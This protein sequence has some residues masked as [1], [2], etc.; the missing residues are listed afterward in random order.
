MATLTS[1]HT[2]RF[3]LILGAILDDKTWIRYHQSSEQERFRNFKTIVDEWLVVN[4]ESDTLVKV[5]ATEHMENFQPENILN[6]ER[7]MRVIYK[8]GHE[9]A[10]AKMVLLA[11]LLEEIEVEWYESPQ[12]EIRE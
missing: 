7:E 4:H 6:L 5:L 1:S 8:S 3:Y 9:L 2:T 12:V 10:A 11:K